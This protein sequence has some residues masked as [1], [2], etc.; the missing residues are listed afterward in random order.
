MKKERYFRLMAHGVVRFIYLI[1]DFVCIVKLARLK[2]VWANL[3][4]ILFIYS[5][6]RHLE[7]FR[8]VEPDAVHETIVSLNLATEDELEK[9]K[10]SVKMGFDLRK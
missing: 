2:K 8:R 3:A 1:I 9:E 4:A 5:S 7:F 6:G 10:E